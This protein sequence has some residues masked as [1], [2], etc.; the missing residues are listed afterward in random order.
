M[1]KVIYVLGACSAALGIATLLGAL[2]QSNRELVLSV[3]GSFFS[4][5]ALLIAA[6]FYLHGRRL[7]SEFQATTA[8]EKKADK[9]NEKI[10]SV[11]NQE[12][13]QVFCRVHVLRL[14]PNCLDRHDDGRNCLYVPAKRAAAAYK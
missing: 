13:A 6:G 8:R 12:A 9:K 3:G 7:R 5:G 10:C 14:C 11:C 1:F 2:G 4:L